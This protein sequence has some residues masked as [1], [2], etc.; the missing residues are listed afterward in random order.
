LLFWP[1]HNHSNG[2][3]ARLEV[4]G[5]SRL[6]SSLVSWS[7]LRG[8]QSIIRFGVID[9][10][11]STRHIR[12][13]IQQAFVSGGEIEETPPSGTTFWLA[14]TAIVL[15]LLFGLTQLVAGI[16]QVYVAYR[17]LNC[18]ANGMQRQYSCKAISQ[19]IWEVLLLQDYLYL[20]IVQS[21]QAGRSFL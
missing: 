16:I 9:Y 17:T 13:Q 8:T 7:R 15:T 6:I 4:G 18:S 19:R 10:S 21:P 20:W 14:V 2:S 12:R 3:S 5:P 11:L 1:V